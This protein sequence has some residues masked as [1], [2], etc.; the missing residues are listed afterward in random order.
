MRRSAAQ[1]WLAALAV[2]NTSRL[3]NGAVDKIQLLHNI[4]TVEFDGVSGHVKLDEETGDRAAQGVGVRMR[5]V[6][7]RLDLRTG[8]EALSAEAVWYWTDAGLER[9][10]PDDEPP[11]WYAGMRG[12]TPPPDGSLCQ[13][14]EV[15][16][17]TTL[18][19]S[20]RSDCMVVLL[21]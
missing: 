1:V 15:F 17:P 3:A 18:S 13:G 5:N 8:R 20:V 2:Q 12:W 6:A 9:V 19:V 10:V 14:G 11:F 21:V 7:T 4:R 16:D